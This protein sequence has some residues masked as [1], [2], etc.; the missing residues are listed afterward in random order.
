M[1]LIDFGG[2]K[3]AKAGVPVLWIDRLSSIAHLLNNNH[4]RNLN[5]LRA[6][7]HKVA[8]VFEDLK[9]NF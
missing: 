8:E 5:R 3:R 7:V 1:T 2:E 6:I 4:R 9:L